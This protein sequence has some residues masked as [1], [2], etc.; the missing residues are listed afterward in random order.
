[1]QK[2]LIKLKHIIIFLLL[3]AVIPWFVTEAVFAVFMSVGDEEIFSLINHDFVGF[4]DYIWKIALGAFLL[5]YVLFALIKKRM[6][7]SAA[8][9]TVIIL[10]IL[11]FAFLFYI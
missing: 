1:M 9:M 11:V 8:L 2:L 7:F 6:P 3:A 5:V 10:Y 4:H